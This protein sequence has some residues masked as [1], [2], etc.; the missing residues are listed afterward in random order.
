M[1]TEGS[2]LQ[3][4]ALLCV[5]FVVDSSILAVVT[6]SGHYNNMHEKTQ[7]GRIYLLLQGSIFIEDYFTTSSSQ[8]L[9][10]YY[11][12]AYLTLSLFINSTSKIFSKKILFRVLTIDLVNTST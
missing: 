6:N 1:K 4:V 10:K 7:S 9:K 2:V 5:M 11:D 3:L 8:H 12:Y